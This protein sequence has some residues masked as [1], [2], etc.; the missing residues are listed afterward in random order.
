MAGSVIY[1]ICERMERSYNRELSKFKISQGL[2]N[3]SGN[4][5]SSKRNAKQVVDDGQNAESI[6]TNEMKKDLC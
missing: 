4:V 3:T 5:S 1:K 6:V 2:T